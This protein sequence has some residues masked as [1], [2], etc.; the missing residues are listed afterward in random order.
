MTDQQPT[1]SLHTF[2]DGDPDGQ[3]GGVKD[4]A[5]DVGTRIADAR[6]AAGRSQA[7][8]AN[9]L[10]VKASTVDKWERGS[11]APRSDRLTALAG[12]LGVSVTWL[13]VGYGNEPTS[14]AGIDDIKVALSRVQTQLADALNDVEV[15]VARLDN[16][17]AAV[18]AGGQSR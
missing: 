10:G 18:D 6:R 2:L 8:I 7:E 16:A 12:I 17:L 9:Q 1:S 15:L 5:G 11:L 4:S 3:P 14:T 13:I